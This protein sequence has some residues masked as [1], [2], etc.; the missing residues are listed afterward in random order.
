M[1]QVFSKLTKATSKKNDLDRCSG[2]EIISSDSSFSSNESSIDDDFKSCSEFKLV[3]TDSSSDDDKYYTG[4]EIC[5]FT[6][7]VF[8]WLSL[9]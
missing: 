3:S 1:G 8:R 7:A 2:P 6:R 4:T 9:F 5:N